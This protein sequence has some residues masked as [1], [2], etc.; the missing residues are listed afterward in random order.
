MIDEDGLVAATIFLFWVC[1]LMLIVANITLGIGE[2]LY[3]STTNMN[4]FIIGGFSMG[5]ALFVPTTI[6]QHFLVKPKR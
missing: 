6:I 1:G 3:Q 2:L 5:V 4:R